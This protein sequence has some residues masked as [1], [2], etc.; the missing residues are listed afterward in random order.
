MDSNL[1][2]TNSCWIIVLT[3]VSTLPHFLYSK[4]SSRAEQTD[5]SM[6]GRTHGNMKP[7]LTAVQQQQRVGLSLR[8]RSVVVICHPDSMRVVVQADMFDTGLQVDGRHLRLGSGSLSE[9]SACGAV[10]SGEAEFTIQAHRRDCGTK[11][12]STKDKIIYSN[13]LV[14]SPEPS[15]GGLLRLDGATIP[16]ACHYEKRNGVDGISLHPTWVPSVSRVSVEDHIDFILLIMTEDWQFARGSYSFFLGDPIYFQVSAITGNH[17]PLRVYV[18]HCVATATPDAETTLRYD[19][20]EN[21]GCLADAYLTNSNSHF[22]PRIEEHELRFQLEAFRFYQEPSNQVYITCYVKA[23][24]AKLTVSSQNRACS[25]IE[26]R[27]RSVDG[28]DQACR[29]CNVSHRVAQPLPTERPKTTISTKAWPSKTSQQSSVQNRPEQHPANYYRFHPSMHQSQHS[30]P[31]QSSAGAMKR[32]VE[33]KAERTIQ[34]GPI[35][36]LA[37]S[38]IDTRPS[39]SKTVLLPKTRTTRDSSSL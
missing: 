21:H 31:R 18:D 28:N 27:W 3:L 9:G 11:L 26:N 20:I 2:R 23:V 33:Y 10:P 30:K 4:P 6:P 7:Q 1:Q 36:V 34:L 38:K 16:V 12:S 35:T 22:L 5:F 24:P 15:S 17:V 37:P 32:G 39:D 13:V 25:M 19:L 8:P 29:S 14:Y